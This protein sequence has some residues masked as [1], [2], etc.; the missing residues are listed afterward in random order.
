MRHRLRL[1]TGENSVAAVTAE[2]EVTISLGEIARILMDASRSRRGWL[3]D[4]SDDPVRI[5]SDLYEVLTTY[6]NLRPGA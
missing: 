6:S 5:S 2:P 1:F 4:L 3:N